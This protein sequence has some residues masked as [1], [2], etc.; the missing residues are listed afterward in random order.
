MLKNEL[1][2]RANESNVRAFD[3]AP[4]DYR[5]VIFSAFLE[6]VRPKE[7]QKRRSE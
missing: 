3:K 4:D 7:S 2:E 5:Q 6:A 1:V